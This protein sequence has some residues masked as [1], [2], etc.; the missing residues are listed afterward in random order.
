MK[1]LLLEVC[2]GVGIAVGGHA[3]TFSQAV[4]WCFAWPGIIAY[5]IAVY[6]LV[7]PL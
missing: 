6:F 2:L 7:N 1:F 3:S 5:R 4:W